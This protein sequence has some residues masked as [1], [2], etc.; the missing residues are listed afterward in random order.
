[1]S[2]VNRGV[3]G[4]T[5][6]PVHFGHLRVAEEVC[7]RLDLAEVIFVPAGEPWMKGAEELAPK[8]HRWE[9][10]VRATVSNPAFVPSRVDIERPGPS[11]AIDTLRDLTRQQ[12]GPWACYF[13]MGMDTLGSLPQW[14]EPDKMLEVCRIAVVTRPDQ[15]EEKAVADVTRELP[16]LMERITFI[17]GLHIGISSTE[18]RR[19]C[20]EGQSIEGLVPETVEGYILEHDLYR[21]TG[22]G[23]ATTA[24]VLYSSEGRKGAYSGTTHTEVA[25]GNMTPT[26]A[27]LARLRE[28]LVHKAVLRGDF[29]L[30]SGA[31]STYYFDGRRVTHDAEGIT[32]I[33]EL[34][35]EILHGAGVEAIGG[36]AAG[37]NPIITAVQIT[38]HQRQRP[39]SG[40]FV[41]AEQKQHGTGQQIEGNL[42]DAPGA[43]VAIV[44]DT[45]TTGG[46]IE[47]AIAVVEAQ[48]FRV[49]KVVVV[50]DRRQGGA[51]KI[52]ARGYD[53]QA[54]F[55]A[56]EDTITPA[57]ATGD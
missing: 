43:R 39:L 23:I 38:A 35:E 26:D 17:R 20:R 10:V 30:S 48:G 13:I 32:L 36:P 42:P 21:Q 55:E 46:S 12:P 45:L 11:Y 37:A 1:M 5:F 18:V 15:D 3:L 54:L 40:F 14:K 57:R 27:R 19:R 9:M 29:T 16:A 25:G 34:V 2:G 50:V 24:R 33:G 47:R 28:L 56:D 8:E 52:R 4:G 22:A 53:V 41:R 31:K 44:D 51:D 6:N 49:A 7:A